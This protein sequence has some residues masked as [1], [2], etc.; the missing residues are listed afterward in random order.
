M[1]SERYIDL[2]RGLKHG[3][4]L[5]RR[6]NGICGDVET[7]RTPGYPLFL[8]VMPS[9]RFAIAVQGVL[10]A[11]V[12]LLIGLF[13]WTCWG[14]AAGAAAELLVALDIPSIVYGA[15]IMSDILFQAEVVA[16][17]VLAL[18]IIWRGQSDCVA[19]AGVL[20]AAVLFAMATMVRPLGIVLPLFA[21]LPAVLLPRLS[22]R[23][24]I[25]MALLAF[26]ISSSTPFAWIARNVQRTGVWILSTDGPIDLYYYKAAGIRWYRGNKSYPAVQDELGRELGWPM[27]QFTD[28]PPSLQHEMIRRALKII[29]HDPVASANMTLRCLG[30]LAI[31]PERGSLDGVLGT[32]TVTPY[33]SVASA[34]RPRF[35]AS[36]NVTTRVHEMLRS[37]L[38]TA[39][40]AVQCFDNGFCMD[41]RGARAGGSRS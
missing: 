4:G 1:D 35:A 3:C 40:V 20:I 26:A 21:A 31:V 39:L 16:G 8:A 38:L 22:W 32:G 29:L 17:I 28:V 25:C 36:G 5:A 23:R 10:G 12:S 33:S 9:S 6:I 41:R 19:F 13:V 27:Q 24:A 14:L 2:A 7:L 37:P 18:W 11:E 34:S 15:M 30:W